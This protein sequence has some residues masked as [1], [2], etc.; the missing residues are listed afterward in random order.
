V[1]RHFDTAILALNGLTELL[2]GNMTA[3]S[4]WVLA[5]DLRSL[6]NYAE[7][8]TLQADG[9]ILLGAKEPIREV[10]PT[11]RLCATKAIAAWTPV[12]G[13]QR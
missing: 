1:N 12:W 9:K 7:I 11:S 8:V 5:V 4:G 13:T 10:I 2:D 3:R 6:D